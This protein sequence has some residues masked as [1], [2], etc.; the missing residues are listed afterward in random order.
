MPLR[1][2]GIGRAEDAIDLW[3][4]RQNAVAGF[5]HKNPDFRFGKFLLRRRNGRREK[6]RVSDMAELDE[7]DSH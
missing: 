1:D 3:T 4:T 5:A 2:I 6:K 7:Q